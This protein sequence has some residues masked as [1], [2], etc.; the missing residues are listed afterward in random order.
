LFNSYLTSFFVSNILPGTITGDFVRIYDTRQHTDGSARAASIVFT[1]R[2]LGLIILFILGGAAWRTLDSPPGLGV[3]IPG[4]SWPVIVLVITGA[5]LIWWMSRSR[6]RVV[7]KVEQWLQSL[8]MTTVRLPRLLLQQP[9]EFFKVIIGTV[10]FQLI[11]ISIVY[12]SIQAAHIN[13]PP[14]LFLAIAP[15]VALAIMLPVSVQGIGVRESLYLSLLAP[16]GVEPEALLAGLTLSYLVGLPF[17][18]WGWLLYSRRAKITAQR[19][20][21]DVP[22]R[23]LLDGRTEAYGRPDSKGGALW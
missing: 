18:L 15:L 23:D 3:D 10:A 16:V 6:W 19:I 1:E 2:L 22:V 7:T 12:V 17:I 20:S 13:I 11:S 21:N 8:I 14:G 5:S 9:I 4:W